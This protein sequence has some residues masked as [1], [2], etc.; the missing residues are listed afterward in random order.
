MTR[1]FTP[2]T[3]GEVSRV[4]DALERVDENIRVV[5]VVEPPLE[6]L[7]VAIHVFRAHLVERADKRTLEQAPHAFHAV[8]VNVAHD[9]DFLGVVYV[10]WRVSRTMPM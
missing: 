10:S 9:P 7:K 3:I 6:L 2:P 8:C 5:S 4:D 1:K